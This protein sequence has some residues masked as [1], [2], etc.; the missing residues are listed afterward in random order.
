[1]HVCPGDRDAVLAVRDDGQAPSARGSRHDSRAR[2]LAPQQVLGGVGSDLCQR[3]AAELRRVVG[4]CRPVGVEV[5]H[6][7][8]AVHDQR[9][10]RSALGEQTERVARAGVLNRGDRVRLIDPAEHVAAV[11]FVGCDR[12]SV[13]T[14]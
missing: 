10:R 9:R 7:A 12:F 14:E 4:I 1:M 2:D 6:L 13:A 5:R 8:F 3:R 11:V